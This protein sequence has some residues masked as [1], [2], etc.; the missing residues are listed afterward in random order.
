MKTKG[1]KMNIPSLN[2]SSVMKLCI[3]Q[4]SFNKAYSGNRIILIITPA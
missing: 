1:L 2:Y 3:F 4:G